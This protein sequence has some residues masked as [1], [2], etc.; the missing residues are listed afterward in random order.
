MALRRSPQVAWQTIGD[1]AVIMNLAGGR[2]LGL[3]PTGALV[4][5]LLE[6]HDEGGLAEAVA[7]RFEI[8]EKTARDDVRSFLAVLR[9]RGLVVEE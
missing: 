9:E 7:Q 3:N 1:E 5:S 8:D 4:W 6:E 2:V